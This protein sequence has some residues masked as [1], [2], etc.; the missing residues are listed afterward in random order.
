MTKK[1]FKYLLSLCTLLLACYGHLSAHTNTEGI[2]YFSTY[3]LSQS[4]RVNSFR[5]ADGTPT[6]IDTSSSEKYKHLFIE[7][8]EIEESEEDDDEKNSSKKYFETSNFFSTLLYSTIPGHFAKGQE[9]SSNFELFSHTI[10]D[11]R[12][13]VFAVFR[14]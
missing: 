2:F 4:A 14:I 3:H 6:I 9:A 8:A 1:L 11:K 7:E 12:Y 10:N 13:I 5:A